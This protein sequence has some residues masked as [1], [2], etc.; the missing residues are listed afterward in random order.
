M[1]REQGEKGKN[2][3]QVWE[4]GRRS[5]DG[6]INRE[7]NMIANFSEERGWMSFNKAVRE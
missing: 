6:K 1:T 4:D 7:D 3:R 2:G 5:R